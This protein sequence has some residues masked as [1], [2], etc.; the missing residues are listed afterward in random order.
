MYSALYKMTSPAARYLFDHQRSSL[1]QSDTIQIPKPF[2][3][4]LLLTNSNDC[5]SLERRD[6]PTLWTYDCSQRVGTRRYSHEFECGV[7]PWIS[8]TLSDTQYA[9]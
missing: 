2:D 6:L 5:I 8:T 4:F 3:I 9:F 7:V 1:I